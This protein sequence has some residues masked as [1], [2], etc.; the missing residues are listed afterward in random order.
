MFFHSC[1][2]QRRRKNQIF[3][4]GNK[5]TV[6]DGMEGVFQEYFNN[7]FRSSNPTRVAI[8][9]SI[10]DMDPRVNS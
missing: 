7:L 5:V 4:M 2:N 10:K 3:E 8:E 1:A 9:M 6:Q